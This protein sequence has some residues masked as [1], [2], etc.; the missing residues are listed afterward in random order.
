M[1]QTP[2]QNSELVLNEDGSIYHLNLRPEQLATT[3]ITVGDPDRVAHI[4]RHFDTI[5]VDVHKREFKTHTGTY[6]GKRIS[7]VSTGI[8]TDNIDIVFNELDALVNIDFE[9]RQ[10]KEKLTELTIIRIGTSG[11]IQ[12]EIPIDS[13]LLS[14]AAIGFDSLLHFYGNTNFFDTALSEA[15]VKHTNWSP[16]KSKPYVVAASEELLTQFSGEGMFHGI[17]ATNVGFY[18]PQGRIL[19]LQTDDNAMNDK[20]ASFSFEDRK[21]TNFEMETSGIYGMARLLGHRALSLNAILA[22]RANGT[23]SEKPLETVDKLILHTL[24]ILVQ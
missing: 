22:N 23:F 20:I 9:T 18:G 1:N 15:F 5:E 2:I 13:F 21:I 8:G 6:K 4:S 3:I 19:R 7:V 24:S 12:P 10:V 11:S 17:T 14:E 16:Q